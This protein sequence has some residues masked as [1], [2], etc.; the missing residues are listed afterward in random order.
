MPPR[1]RC[2]SCKVQG[3]DKLQTETVGFFV[4]VYCKNCGDIPGVAP[5]PQQTTQPNVT[6]KPAEKFQK[7][8]LV[9]DMTPPRNGKPPAP[10]EE[11]DEKLVRRGPFSD[12]GRSARNH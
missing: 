6:V 1:P 4:V 12:A 10:P 2:S 8:P 9:I 7:E 5:K 3:L 11:R